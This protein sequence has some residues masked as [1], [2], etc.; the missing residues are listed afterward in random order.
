V[1]EQSGGATWRSSLAESGEWINELRFNSRAVSPWGAMRRT[2][3]R[4]LIGALCLSE[5]LGGAVWRCDLAEQFGEVRRMDQG[6]PIQQPGGFA[7][8]CDEAN[9][10]ALSDWRPLLGGVTWRSR[11]A[12]S[13]GWI[14]ELR[15]NSR[16]VSPWGAMRRT[17]WRSLIGV[18]CLAE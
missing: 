12:E 4:S 6:A 17:A 2:A 8:G 5:W 15:F 14:N 3:W 13:G 1:A 11:L 9:S 10:L 18:L 16:A 7:L